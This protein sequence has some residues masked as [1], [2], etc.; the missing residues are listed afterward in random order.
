MKSLLSYGIADNVKN[1]ENLLES[2]GGMLK[3]IGVISTLM[4]SIAI[5]TALSMPSTHKLEFG[6][7]ITFSIG[8]LFISLCLAI[9]E[10]LAIFTIPRDKI[11]QLSLLSNVFALPGQFVIF[12]ILAYLPA[13]IP[14]Y[15]CRC[16]SS[17]SI[18]N[19]IN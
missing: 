13:I 1:S 5:S 10:L 4:L 15:N 16:S 7:F 18:K 17:T 11:Q 6:I 2:L 8:L 9:I 3:S 19:T 14:I 12:G